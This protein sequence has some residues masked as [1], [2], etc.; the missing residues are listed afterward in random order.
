MKVFRYNAK[1]REDREFNTCG[2]EKNPN[3]L[4]FYAKSLDYAENYRFVYNEDYDVVYEC[5]LEVA[6]VNANLF[7]MVA[8]FESLNTFHNY[9]NA[10]ISEMK[11]DY[12]YF[13]SRAKTKAEKEM[14]QQ[15]IDNLINEKQ[16]IANNLARNEF[17]GLSDFETQNE[18]VSE[19]KSLG[20]QGYETKNEVVVF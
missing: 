3:A 5:A 6:E 12:E 1:K 18:L 11:S 13:L 19:L 4:K 15:H 14:Y 17:Q 8:N 7:D 16:S 2:R 9:A 20:F 10:I